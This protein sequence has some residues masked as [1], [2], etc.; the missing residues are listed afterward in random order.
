MDGEREIDRAVDLATMPLFVR[1]GAIIPM[2]P[3]KQYTNE[4]VVGPLTLLLSKESL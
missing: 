3:V 2:G 4:K 1:S